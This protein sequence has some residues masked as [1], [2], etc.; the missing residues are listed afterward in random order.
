[1]ILANYLRKEIYGV[2]IAAT[3]IL[4]IVLILNQL[5]HYLNS[6]ASS[7]IST[8]TVLQIMSLQVPLLLGY[9][10][11]LGF[12]IGILVALGRMYAETEM[13]IYKAAG[14]GGGRI[15]R[16]LLSFASVLTVV[17]AFLMVAVN[18]QI[19]NARLQILEAGLANVSIDK[20]LP[21]QFLTMGQ[22]WTLYA[23]SRIKGSGVLEHVFCAQERPSSVPLAAPTWDIIMA[24]TVREV[25]GAKGQSPYWVFEQGYRY[26]GI[27]GEPKLQITRFQE[28]RF[29]RTE[30]L[31]T[32]SPSVKAAPLAALWAAQLTDARAAAELHWRLAIPIMIWP[33]TVLAFLFAPVNPRQGRF[34]QLFPAFLL[35][36]LYADL[37]FMGKLWLKNQRIPLE[38]GLWWVH[39]LMLGLV[40]LMGFWKWKTRA[41]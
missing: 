5:V 34:G 21:G 36:L 20:V 9:L 14:M 22:G 38:W 39:G 17:V 32:G 19:E 16:I 40:L 30:T 24:K 1:M 2:M 7:E 8:T 4:L 18:P 3:F 27:P 41:S 29:Y 31:K 11:P 10:L 6:A 23:Q 35:Y 26:Y 15:L 33:L 25:K 13:T 12:Y 37:L 28:D